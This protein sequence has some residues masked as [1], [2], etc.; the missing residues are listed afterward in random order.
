[1]GTNSVLIEEIQSDWT[2]RV[3][4]FERRP[5]VYFNRLSKLGEIGKARSAE[6]FASKMKYYKETLLPRFVD[7]WQETMMAICQFFAFEELAVTNLYM[8]TYETGLLLKGMHRNYS[9]PPRSIYT[10][11]PRKMGFCEVHDW[12]LFLDQRVAQIKKKKREKVPIEFWRLSLERDAGNADVK[13][14]KAQVH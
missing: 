13:K 7:H 2:K 12:P 5:K 3:D 6:E 11:L 8:H 14:R 1:L 10:E 4:D 9:L